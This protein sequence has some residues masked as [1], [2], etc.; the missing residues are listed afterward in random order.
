MEV[1]LSADPQQTRLAPSCFKGY[2]RWG[3]SKD[4]LGITDGE[5]S[6]RVNRKTRFIFNNFAVV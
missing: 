1:A 5:V 3:K 6:M 2:R 4:I